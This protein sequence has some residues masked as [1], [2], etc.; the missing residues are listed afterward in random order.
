MDGGQSIDLVAMPYGELGNIA[1]TWRDNQAE[2]YAGP[3]G[4]WG[5][6]AFQCREAIARLENYRE[7]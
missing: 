4:A 7:K 2:R 6:E 3:F 1:R 5:C